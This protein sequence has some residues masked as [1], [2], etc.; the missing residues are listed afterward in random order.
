MHHI[1]KSKPTRT[2]LLKLKEPKH[3]PKT[4]SSEQV[5]QLIDNCK[6]IRDKFLICLLH[7]SGMR[8]GQALGLRH[9]D[10]ESWD[11]LIKVIPRDDNA[12]GARAKGNSAYNVDVTK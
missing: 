6:R 12:N 9:E 2:R 5:K 10:I 8:I 4:L 11:N 7:E 1:T 3:Y